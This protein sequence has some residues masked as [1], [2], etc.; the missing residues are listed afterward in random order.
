ML[1]RVPGVEGLRMCV[2]SA[3]Q[4]LG[5][6]LESV[7]V[8]A[9]SAID[10]FQALIRT[11]GGSHARLV[12]RIRATADGLTNKKVVTPP[13]RREDVRRAMHDVVQAL[14][15]RSAVARMSV[16]IIRPCKDDPTK[17]EY[18][19]ARAYIGYVAAS[20]GLPLVVA[21]WVTG[22]GAQSPGV[23]YQNLEG[24]PLD[25]R[26]FTGLLED[27]CTMPVPIVT[28][29]DTTGKLVQVMD[30]ARAKPGEAMDAVIAYRLPRVAPLPSLDDPPIYL[31]V[32]TMTVPAQRMV[33]DLYV[34][35][36]M[37]VGCTPS[38]SL[39]LGR[40]SGGCDLIDRWH[41]QIDGSPVLGLLGNGLKNAHSSGWER[42]AELTRHV[43]AKL[44]WDPQEYVGYRCDE[45]WPLW[46]CDY[47][48]ALDYR[49]HEGAEK[50]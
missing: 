39:Y 12:A 50:S 23:D 25:E 28:S 24:V 27:F 16:S 26:E 10:D 7:L 11:G 44:G 6:P 40:G 33:S 1:T 49:A 34:H 46:N 22:S 14:S 18:V 47:V 5:A 9:E 2:A 30:Q 35:R 41:E 8:G 21:S 4:K 37:A 48:V 3:R 42:H 36:S 32:T 31:E 38:V 45:T 20:G 29:R 13:G 43:F 19:H 17:H 15:G